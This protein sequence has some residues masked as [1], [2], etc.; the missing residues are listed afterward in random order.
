M[1]F[2]V[3]VMYADTSHLCSSVKLPHSGLAEN[4]DHCVSWLKSGEL[5]H[6]TQQLDKTIIARLEKN[7]FF[8]TYCPFAP[9]SLMV[10]LAPLT[11]GRHGSPCSFGGFITFLKVILI[12]LNSV[13]HNFYRVCCY[14]LNLSGYS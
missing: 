2:I 11:T 9:F 10:P 12:C 8:P 1:Y 13:R 14:L 5:I 6:T 3:N 7:S 4:H